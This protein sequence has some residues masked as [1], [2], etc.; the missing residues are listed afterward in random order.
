MPTQRYATW[1]K[2]LAGLTSCLNYSSD[3]NS[4]CYR[5]SMGGLTTWLSPTLPPTV[6]FPKRAAS[7]RRRRRRHY[8]TSQRW[9]C[10]AVV[11]RKRRTKKA[12]SLFLF[13][14]PPHLRSGW[15]LCIVLLYYTSILVVDGIQRRSDHADG[16]TDSRIVPLPAPPPPFGP[17]VYI[18]SD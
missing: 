7:R 13:P 11:G 5:R 6:Y 12:A 17:H 18:Q 15:R 8:S 14:P 1:P 4:P 9:W 16:V 10:G 3:D 2:G